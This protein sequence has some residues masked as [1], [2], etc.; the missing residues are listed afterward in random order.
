[1]T[2]TVPILLYHS[3]DSSCAP[4]F[5]RWCVDPELFARHMAYLAEQRYTALTISRLAG[6]LA[7]REPLP[8]RPVAITFDDGFADFYT[9]ALPALARHAF[10]AT[11]YLTAGYLG[12]TSRWL[13]AEG[14]GRRP[15][16]TWQQ[17][18]E[19]AAAGIEPGSHTNSHPQLDL[20]PGAEARAEIEGSRRRLEDTL[21]RPVTSFAYPHGYHSPAVARLVREAG[22][23]SACAV[24]H[25]MSALNDDPFAL[26]RIIV[27]SDTEV[28]VFEHLLMGD[29]LRVTP[30]QN[31]ATVGWRVARRW[32]RTFERGRAAVLGGPA[33]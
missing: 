28:P 12:S 6:I 25:A 30:H 17:A 2:D 18:G 19:L 15:M 9:G 24:K 21:G 32:R 11:L 22:Y 26:A 14:E 3:I 29:G 8:P 1:M 13:A 31:A 5:R 10:P 23:T 27:P 20:L 4:A 7:G 33:T 16:L